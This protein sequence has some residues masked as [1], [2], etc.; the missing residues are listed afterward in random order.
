MKVTNSYKLQIA[1]EKRM[2][3]EKAKEEKEKEIWK[4]MPE[5]GSERGW[6]TGCKCCKSN[7]INSKGKK[8][9]F[10][11]TSCSEASKDG[12]KGGG[13]GGGWWELCIK[14]SA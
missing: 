3:H 1:E 9:S 7:S 6:K 11:K 14:F 10:L 4:G 8:E 12:Q 5:E 2:A 13:E